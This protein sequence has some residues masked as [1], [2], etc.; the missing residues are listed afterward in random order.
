[1]GEQEFSKCDICGQDAHVDRKYYYYDVKCECCNSKDSPH[2]EIVRHC[3]NCE[4][5][6]PRR[7]S[8]SLGA[9]AEKG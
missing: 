1:M 2:F 7:I 4:P 9:M 8:L 6:P 5:K 3:A